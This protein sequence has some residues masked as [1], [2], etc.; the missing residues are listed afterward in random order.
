MSFALPSIFT[1][2]AQ[3]ARPAAPFNRPRRAAHDFYPT[4]PEATRALLSVEVFH[5]TVWEP[6]CGD[7]AIAKVLHAEG[8]DVVSTDLIDRGYGTGNIDFLQEK[9]PR[10]RNIITN[11]PYGR[12]LRH[13]PT[14]ANLSNQFF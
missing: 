13:L 8:Y 5:G 7:G 2:N 11:P 6:A 14:V 3:R 12:G 10:A 9:Q 4:P 1:L